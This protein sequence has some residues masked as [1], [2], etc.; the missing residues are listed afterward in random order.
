MGQDVQGRWI[1]LFP[2]EG[3]REC[4]TCLRSGGAATVQCDG[5]AIVGAGR[6]EWDGARLTVALTVLAREGRRVAAPGPFEFAVKGGGNTL[7]VTREG[8]AFEWVRRLR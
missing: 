8:R 1:G 3:A 2:L 5:T 6:Y 7:R 4:A